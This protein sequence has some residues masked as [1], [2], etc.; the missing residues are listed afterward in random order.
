MLDEFDPVPAP[1]RHPLRARCRWSRP[2]T[3][4]ASSRCRRGRARARRSRRRCCST[5]ASRCRRAGTTVELHPLP[6]APAG[7]AL[8]RTTRAARRPLRRRADDVGGAGRARAAR[9]RRSSTCRWTSTSSASARRSDLDG[10]V[11]LLRVRPQSVVG[12]LDRIAAFDVLGIVGARAVRVPVPRRPGVLRA[13]RLLGAR[14]QPGRHLG[15]VA[16]GPGPV[17][18]QAAVPQRRRQHRARRHDRPALDAPAAA[19]PARRRSR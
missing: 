11:G 19:G 3:C 18:L 4:R 6:D 5:R 8:V 16:D 13:R 10:Q 9:G 1:H 2:A 17:E 15:G 14:R 7:A 12:S